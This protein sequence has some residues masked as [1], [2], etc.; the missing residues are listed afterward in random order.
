MFLVM[1][2]GEWRLWSWIFSRS[3]P[4][5]VSALRLNFVDY[6]VARTFPRLSGGGR[7]L[8]EFEGIRKTIQSGDVS[9]VG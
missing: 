7:V 5:L 3:I 2:W 8:E 4:E 6:G 1:G 9:D